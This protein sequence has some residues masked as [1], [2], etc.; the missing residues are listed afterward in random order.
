MNLGM[1][2]RVQPLVEAAQKFITEHVEPVDQEFLE[3]DWF[4]EAVTETYIPL[5]ETFDSLVK[6][7]VD[8]RLTMSLTFW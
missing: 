1:S 6:D 5:I 4:Y 7:N 8:F 3:E 2:D